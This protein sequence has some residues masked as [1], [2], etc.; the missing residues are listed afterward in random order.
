MHWGGWEK[1][2][3]DIRGLATGNATQTPTSAT[4]ATPLP[5]AIKMES[6]PVTGPLPTPLPPIPSGTREGSAGGSPT[7]GK[8]RNQER[9][10]IANII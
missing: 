6:G 4:W 9:I 1:L 8:P 5:S 2:Q 10:S 7:S 3:A